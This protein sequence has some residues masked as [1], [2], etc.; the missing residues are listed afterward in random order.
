[1]PQGMLLICLT[2]S[3]QPKSLYRMQSEAHSLNEWGQLLFSFL[4]ALRPVPETSALTCLL[5]VNL[6]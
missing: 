6:V 3:A 4:A 1:M 2:A 5:M